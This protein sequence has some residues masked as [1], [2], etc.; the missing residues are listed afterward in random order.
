MVRKMCCLKEVRNALCQTFQSVSVAAVDAELTQP[1]A[2][3]LK[4]GESFNE[5]SNRILGLVSKMKSADHYKSK[6]EQRC[7]I[8]GGTPKAY[9]VTTEAIMSSNSEYQDALSELIIWETLLLDLDGANDEALVMKGG[10]GKK[11]YI[12]GKKRKVAKSCWQKGRS[13]IGKNG[14]KEMRECFKCG[15]P[16]H[17]P[18][19]WSSKIDKDIDA[20]TK[21][22]L[23]VSMACAA[24]AGT[25]K[26]SK[27]T[28]DSACPSHIS[29][30]WKY[31]DS[32]TPCKGVD[33]VGQQWNDFF[34]GCG[35][36]RGRAVVRGVKHMVL[37][38]DVLYAPDIIDYPMAFQVSRKGASELSSI[39]TIRPQ[40]SIRWNCGA[41]RL[42]KC[43][44]LHFET[45]EGP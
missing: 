24:R 7:A 30:N 22:M 44:K 23:T 5:F 45:P 1:Q 42:V 13:G 8:L 3:V 6:I 4:K 25:Q 35:D 27:W 20:P 17:I 15:K 16:G 21:V 26:S 29:N 32:F 19:N 43:A 28:P 39:R 40:K 31:S 36:C 14:A 10:T 33:T 9:D 37:L 12:C 11:C 18:E 41:S 34:T 38:H 2:A